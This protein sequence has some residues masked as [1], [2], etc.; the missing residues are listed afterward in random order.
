VSTANKNNDDLLGSQGTMP[1]QLDPCYQIVDE[2]HSDALHD[3]QP[4]CAEHADALG[5]ECKEG[6]HPDGGN[7]AAVQVAR[8]PMQTK[9]WLKAL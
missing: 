7:G 3:L 5:E 9:Q 6:A 4:L 2:H 1:E 8:E